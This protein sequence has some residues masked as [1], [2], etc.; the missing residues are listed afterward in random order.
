MKLTVALDGSVSIEVGDPHEAATF[1]RA[2][3]NGKAVKAKRRAKSPPKELESESVPL[4]SVLVETWNW[5][6]AHD[7]AEGIRSREVAKGL[8]VKG[9][10]AVYRLN[11]LVEKE[12]AYRTRPGYYRAG[13]S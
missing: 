6:V 7:D 12:L 10:T 2:L 13:D 3:R 8:D 9:S 4:S 11:K 1:V 5:L